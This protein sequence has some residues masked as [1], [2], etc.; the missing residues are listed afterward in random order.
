MYSMFSKDGIG[1]LK[2]FV[3]SFKN[4]GTSSKV[5]L[6]IKPML[7]VGT[8]TVPMPNYIKVEKKTGV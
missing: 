8:Y 3:S 4:D 1:A 6:R 7:N 2:N 5:G